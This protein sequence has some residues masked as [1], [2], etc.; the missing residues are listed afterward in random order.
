MRCPRGFTLVEMIMALTITGIL[1]AM[2]AVFIARPVE[3]YVASSRRAGMTDVAD[4]A[5]KRMA[6]DIRTAVPNSVR[7][8]STSSAPVASCS[9]S[10][11]SNCYLEYLPARSGGRYCTDVDACPSGSGGALDF[12]ADADYFD[13]LGPTHEV[14]ANDFLV[15]YNT[16]QSGLDAYAGDNIRP[17]SSVSAGGIT[18][19]G[20]KLPYSSPSH[21]FQAVPASGPVTYACESIGGGGTGS[22][23]LRRHTAYATALPFG[24]LQ[25]M[26]GPG[27]GTLLADDLSGC[28][29]TY[30]AVSAANGLV[31]LSLTLSRE[32]ESITLH[33]QIHVDNIP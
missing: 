14:G 18:L 11:A 8:R 9:A 12:G 22:G 29:F 27:G 31:T 1:A 4:L 5:L 30:D 13:V 33:Q 2:V 7:L 15:V 21:R 6:L 17:V 19:A 24:A 20:A 3:G 23:S 26:P 10:L 28:A 16:G 25:P 32:G